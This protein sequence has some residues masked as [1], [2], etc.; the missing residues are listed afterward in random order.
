MNRSWFLICLVIGAGSSRAQISADFQT[1]FER[2]DRQ[3]VRLSPTAF[4]ELPKNL[5]AELQRRGCTIPQVPVIERRHNV[6]KGEFAKPGQI[7]W[8]VLCTVGMVSSILF[9]WNGSQANPAEIASAR[10]IDRLQSWEGGKIV[11]SRMITPVRKKYL[12][13]HYSTHG[14]EKSPID[15]QGIDDAFAGKASVVLYSHQGKW[16]RLTGAD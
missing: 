4:P 13:D 2:A 1:A 12:V 10:D 15:H 9:F 6:I 16:L 3:I 7:D 5:L 11:Y 14:G 8:G